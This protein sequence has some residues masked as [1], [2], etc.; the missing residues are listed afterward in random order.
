MEINNSNSYKTYNTSLQDIDMGIDANNTNSIMSLLRNSIYSNPLES[1]VREVL[2]NA[3]DAHLRAGVKTPLIVSTE[4][5]KVSSQHYFSVED[6]GESMNVS[7]IKEVYSQMGTSSK[8]SSNT[9]MGMWGIGSA[10]PLAYTDEF[11]ITTKTK[12]NNKFI[13]RKWVQ[14]IDSSQIGKISL[15]EEKELSSNVTGT[16]IKVP[17]K[18]EDTDK[19]IQYINTY[20]SYCLVS[21]KT[22]GFSFKDARPFFNVLGKDWGL[23]L[24]TRNWYSESD[25]FIES[26]IVVA[27][28]PYRI[29][30]NVLKKHIDNKDYEVV[31]KSL[32]DTNN[33]RLSNNLDIF[34]RFITASWHLKYVLTA[35]IGD[36]DLSASREDLQYTEKTCLYLYKALFRMYQEYSIHLEIDYSKNPSYLQACINYT[37]LSNGPLENNVVS[38][39]NWEKE[40]LVLDRKPLV[41]KINSN[42]YLKTYTVE[43]HG[44]SYLGKEKRKVLTSKEANRVSCF[45]LSSKEKIKFVL[46]DTDYKNYSKFI[47]YYLLTKLP[48]DSTI[49]LVQPEQIKLLQDWVL[50]EHLLIKLS[51]IVLD[52]KKLNKKRS[53]KVVRDR[54][55]FNSLQYKGT[56]IRER[57]ESYGIFFNY[58]KAPSNP[59]EKQYY[60]LESEFLDL[61]QV[62]IELP[63]LGWNSVRFESFFNQYLINK[64]ISFNN[65]WYATKPS[66]YFSNENW[67]NLSSLIKEEFKQLDKEKLIRFNKKLFI[68]S[69]V[70]LVSFAFENLEPAPLDNSSLYFKLKE[71][72]TNI[73]KDIESLDADFKLLAS[74]TNEDFRT[75]IGLYKPFSMDSQVNK[76]RC[77]E[78]YQQDSDLKVYIEFLN[79]YPLLK[80]IDEYS[81][82]KNHRCKQSWWDYIEARSLVLKDSKTNI[83]FEESSKS[84]KEFKA[85]LDYYSKL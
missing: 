50:D 44:S 67:I 27:G 58:N 60:I 7:K 70:P 23:L 8:T 4:Q 71:K 84:N 74:L 35:H 31:I 46:Q 64:E 59:S 76:L 32:I 57:A 1:L 80:D 14:Y 20:L 38:N 26:S 42:I 49:Y 3:I 6:F 61:A 68:K 29:N 69:Y 25:S 79:N 63:K 81:V 18:V 82:Y 37:N 83:T 40:N 62:G 85:M 17:F 75:M 56:V 12:E 54:S 41:L 19:L 9:E 45:Y 24:N 22:K 15:L 30:K 36:V 13:E 65:V 48:K 2:S 51:D 21:Y 47:K 53:S 28:I 10:S 34:N 16:I 77:C 73:K 11:F 52:Y 78:L 43:E 72:L 33:K 66:K 39:I 5:D 55:V